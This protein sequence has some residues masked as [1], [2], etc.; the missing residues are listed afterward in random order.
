MYGL[1]P[2]CDAVVKRELKQLDDTLKQQRDLSEVK[3]SPLLALSSAE[4]KVCGHNVVG[5]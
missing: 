2:S 3:E 4:P 5:S 1:C